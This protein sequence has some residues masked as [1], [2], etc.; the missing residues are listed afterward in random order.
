MAGAAFAALAAGA[1]WASVAQTRKLMRE[2]AQP[3]LHVQKLH[4]AAHAAS[5]REFVALVIYNA[6]SGIAKQTGFCFVSGEQLSEGFVGNGFLRSNETAHIGTDL[7]ATSAARGV[8][9]CIT[10]ENEAHVWSLEGERKTLG[11]SKDKPL[12]KGKE[13]YA[14]HYPKDDLTRLEKVASRLGNVPGL[15]T[16]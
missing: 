12:V 4:V 7:A 6:G 2:S 13:A 8:V 1:S 14:L 16:P 15:P 9:F 3:E 5:A 10:R 11:F